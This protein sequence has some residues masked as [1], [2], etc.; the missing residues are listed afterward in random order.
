[1]DPNYDQLPETL[2]VTNDNSWNLSQLGIEYNP[3]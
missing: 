3:S 2:T 1:M